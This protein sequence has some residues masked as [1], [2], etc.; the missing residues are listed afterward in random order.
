MSLKGKFEVIR[1]LVKRKDE[2]SGHELASSLAAICCSSDESLLALSSLG[3]AGA[4]RAGLC[5]RMLA[6][7]D[8]SPISA[9]TA[10]HESRG[11]FLPLPPLQ[12]RAWLQAQVALLPFDRQT[13]VVET[14]LGV[15]AA[16]NFLYVA[17]WTESPNFTFRFRAY[18]LR[19]NARA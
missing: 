13:L 15:V 19:T 3:Q 7:L 18:V 12:A 8:S 5:S 11:D 16:V 9:E 14:V 4:S 17:G 2:V 1:S 6:A 10:L